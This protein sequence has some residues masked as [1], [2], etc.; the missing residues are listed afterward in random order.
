MLCIFTCH[1]P[2]VLLA[3]PRLLLRFGEAYR[4]GSGSVICIPVSI[5]LSLLT[6]YNSILV[7]IKGLHRVKTLTGLNPHGFPDCYG[8]QSIFFTIKGDNTFSSLNI[9]LSGNVILSPHPK[10]ASVFGSHIIE[11]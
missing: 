3:S 8:K 2:L 4:L 9:S 1:L 5:Q 7:S 6:F 10:E 11:K